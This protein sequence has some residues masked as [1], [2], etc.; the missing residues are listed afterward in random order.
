MN[1]Y[2]RRAIERAVLWTLA[3]LGA[4]ALSG[5]STSKPSMIVHPSSR[6]AETSGYLHA[7]EAQM[8]DSYDDDVRYVTRY[9]TGVH[10]SQGRW[11]MADGKPSNCGR[12]GG[13][14][15][16]TLVTDPSGVMDPVVAI[17]EKKHGIMFSRPS[18]YPQTNDGQHSI[19]KQKGCYP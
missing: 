9:V 8:G 16:D 14:V 18:K 13:S 3:I 19:M 4:V 12:A 1:V 2:H 7:A 17:H 10:K 11:V 5:C 15:N 6:K